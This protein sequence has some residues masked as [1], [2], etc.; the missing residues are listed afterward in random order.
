MNAALAHGQSAPTTGGKQVICLLVDT[1]FGYLREFAK[2][3]REHGLDTVELINSARLGETIDNLNP[4]IVFLNLNASD[5][6]DC[7]RGLFALK[8][9]K[10]TGRVQLMG[11]CDQ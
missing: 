4:D 11:R 5:P 1:D 6:S 8:E 10:F 7:V 9:G 3:L 2:S